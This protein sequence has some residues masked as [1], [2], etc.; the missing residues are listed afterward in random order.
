MHAIDMRARD[1][2][3]RKNHEMEGRPPPTRILAIHA[4]RR[5]VACDAVMTIYT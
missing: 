3:G 4:L 2:V 1:A 5:Y